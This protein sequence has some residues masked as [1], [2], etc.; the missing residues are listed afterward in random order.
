MSK[1]RLLATVD[2][3]EESFVRSIWEV[4][5]EDEEELEEDSE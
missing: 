3:K 1:V 4:L 5:E 2:A